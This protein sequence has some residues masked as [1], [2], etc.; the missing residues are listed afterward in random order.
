MTVAVFAVAP[1]PV[2]GQ[3][4]LDGPEGRHA[5]AVRRLRVG[6]RLDV[7]DGAGGVAECVV[8]EVHRDALDCRVLTRRVDPTPTPRLVVV[9]ALA[10]NDRGE[11]AVEL[12]TEVGVDVV[13]PWSAHRSVV[14]WE[15]E[16]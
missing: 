4:R 6:E 7:T 16:R 8:V 1:L 3:F 12:M 11:R 15:G 13:V 5:A 10:K 9:Q 2:T 14:R